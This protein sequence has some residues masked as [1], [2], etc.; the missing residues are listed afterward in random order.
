MFLW[1]F[2]NHFQWSLTAPLPH[3]LSKVNLLY[4]GVTNRVYRRTSGLVLCRFPWRG[5]DYGPICNVPQKKVRNLFKKE[6]SRWNESQNSQK[7]QPCKETIHTCTSYHHVLV[8]MNIYTKG[9]LVVSQTLLMTTIQDLH[10]QR[11]Q[12]YILFLCQ[13]QFPFYIYIYIS[14]YLFE[15]LYHVSALL[16]TCDSFSTDLVAQYLKHRALLGHSLL[17]QLIYL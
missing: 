7:R 1:Y 2:C 17:G 6:M 9:I 12:K 15:T 14:V 16:R 3:I 5:M 10:Q 11:V 13:C 8:A 4:L